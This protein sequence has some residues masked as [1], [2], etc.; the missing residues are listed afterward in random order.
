MFHLVF[1]LIIIIFTDVYMVQKNVCPCEPSIRNRGKWMRQLLPIFLS[2]LASGGRREKRGEVAPS[3]LT[4]P[5]LEHEGTPLDVIL[6]S[7]KWSMF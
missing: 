2:I 3:S 4:T 6:G 7:P 1:F 5:V